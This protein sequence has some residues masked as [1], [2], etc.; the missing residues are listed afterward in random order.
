M[1]ITLYLLRRHAEFAK[2]TLRHHELLA[3]RD[4]LP[5]PDESTE[6]L[7][8]M[9]DTPAHGVMWFDYLNP[10]I[11]TPNGDRPLSKSAGA[12]LLVKFDERV[13]AVTFGTGFHAIGHADVEPDFGLRVAANCVAANS[14]TWA[15][16]RGLGKGKRNATSR[17]AQ[18]GEVFALGLLTD[19]EWIRQFG[20]YVT[21]PGFARSAKGA[22]SLQLDFDE[23]FA[24]AD[25]PSKLRQALDLYESKSYRDHFPF[26]DYFR[27]ETD[28]ERIAELDA[29]MTE[30]M[31][32]R[33]SEVGFAMPDELDVVADRYRLSRYRRQVVLREL[34]TESVYSAIDSLEGWQNPL[35]CNKVQA[36]D[37]AG[38]SVGAKEELRRYVV[39]LVRHEVDGVNQ[40]YA[41]T[42]GAWFRVDR[43]YAEIVDRYLADNIPDITETL[44]MPEWDDEYLIRHVDGNYG[45]DRYNRHSCALRGHALLDRDFYRG[46]AGERVEICDQL[47]ADKKLICVKRMDG[48]DKMSHLFQQGSVSA[49]LI[50]SN[51]DYRAK[52][53]AK[54]HELDP[55]AQFGHPSD[56]TIV[57]AIATGKPG[58]LKKS[59][60]FFT[61]AALRTHSLAIRSTGIRVAIA[62]ISR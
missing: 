37:A 3:Q 34:R 10:I 19:E 17:L 18:P 2:R 54:L 12:V 40:D 46:R 8:F 36:L 47:T 35:Q 31:R 16:A 22:D 52:L 7:L 43:G 14:L 1:R 32:S 26:L 57:Y 23:T 28:K 11:A 53:M 59:M 42:A 49:Q 58:P 41:V 51:D 61:R 48:S 50:M 56:W 27:R 25:L 60:Y 38:G 29:R 45:E 39:G 62:R 5:P 6:W 20:G 30:C 4:L 44:D 33:D 9:R 24:L 13:F 21:I 55:V 15:D